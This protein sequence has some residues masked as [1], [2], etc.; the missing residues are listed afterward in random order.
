ISRLI[1][2]PSPPAWLDANIERLADATRRHDAERVRRLL[3]ALA[4]IEEENAYPDLTT[5]GIE[6]G[7]FPASPIRLR[8][9][10]ADED[11]PKGA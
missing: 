4:G 8:L 5:S 6:I 9:E 3:F 1:P 10:T 7:A 2:I 11:T